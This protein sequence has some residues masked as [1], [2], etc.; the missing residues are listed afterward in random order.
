LQTMLNTCTS[1][2]SPPEDE[3]HVGCRRGASAFTV[4]GPGWHGPR[5]GRLNGG[6]DSLLEEVLVAPVE[7]FLEAADKVMNSTLLLKDRAEVPIKPANRQPCSNAVLARPT[8]T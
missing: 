6:V 7:T 1:W 4:G 8:A 3:R 5:A 2:S